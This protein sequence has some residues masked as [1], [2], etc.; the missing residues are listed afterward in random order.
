MREIKSM[1]LE[2]LSVSLALLHELE[3]SNSLKSVLSG[4]GRWLHLSSE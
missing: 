3:Q 4:L 1:G 2:V